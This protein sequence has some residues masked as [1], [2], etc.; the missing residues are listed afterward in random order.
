MEIIRITSSSSI[1][2]KTFLIIAWQAILFS[3]TIEVSESFDV[4]NIIPSKESLICAIGI[5]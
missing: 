2:R 4:N 1:F 5:V 3:D